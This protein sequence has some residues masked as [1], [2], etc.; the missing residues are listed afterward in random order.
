M[1]RH[2]E[3]FGTADANRNN[4][5]SRNEKRAVAQRDKSG[6]R[7]QRRVGTIDCNDHFDQLDSNAQSLRTQRARRHGVVR[8]R[9]RPLAEPRKLVDRR[10][11]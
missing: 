8:S 5:P 1:E 2:A 10:Y 4:V 7:N 11:Q 6:T 9:W 3:P